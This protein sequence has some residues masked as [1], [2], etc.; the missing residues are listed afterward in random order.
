MA[1]DRNSL[2]NVMFQG[3]ATPANLL[4]TKDVMGYTDKAPVWPF[5]PDGARKLVAEAK[6]AGV[7]V[8]QE[9]TII[10][11]IGIYPNSTE[12][13]EAVQGWLTDIGLNVKLQMLDVAAWAD[14][15]NK[16]DPKT[17]AYLGQLS[18]GNEGGDSAF[19]MA[20]LK[21]G[22]A[23]LFADQKLADLIAE[24][25]VASGD[26][27]QQA[28]EAVWIYD[29]DNVVATIPLVHIQAIWGLSPRVDWT[30][31]FDNLVL[32]KTVKMK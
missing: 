26:A 4:I 28:F 30:P 14:A 31:R 24:A 18:H 17:A 32:V 29:H 11:R 16:S 27:R 9:I 1:I 3:Y 10:G 20:Y 13:M 8:D 12:V 25:E 6:A 22:P 21:P 19:T 5:D 15:L 7:P 23:N 2:A